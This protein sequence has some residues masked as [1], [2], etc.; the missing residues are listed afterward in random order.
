MTNPEYNIAFT[1]CKINLYL[2]FSGTNFN[3][4]VDSDIGTWHLI[5]KAVCSSLVT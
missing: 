1:Y 4:V 5:Y 2:K 3:V